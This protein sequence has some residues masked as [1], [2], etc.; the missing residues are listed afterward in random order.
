M[1]RLLALITV[2]ALCACALA[3]PAAAEEEGISDIWSGDWRYVV[4]ED[5]TASITAYRGVPNDIEIPT[6]IDG[7]TVTEVGEK[8]FLTHSITGVKIPDNV[9][10]IGRYGFGMCRQLE[11]I[12]L[13]PHLERIGTAAF[14]DC[15]VLKKVEIPDS[16]S[17]VAGN[18]FAGCVKL[19]EIIVSED[20]PYLEMRDGALFS[21]PDRRLIGVPLAFS[22]SEYAVPEGTEILADQALMFIYY[23]ESI[24][25]PD[26]VKKIG[27]EAI[28]RC[29]NLKS[30]AIPDSVT[31][32]GER[33]F[34]QNSS[35]Q[36]VVLP[37]GLKEIPAQAFY[38]C[39]ALEKINL[40][41]SLEKIGRYAFYNCKLDG[42]EVPEGV[43]VEEGAF[44]KYEGAKP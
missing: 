15:R 43:E 14:M 25:I 32:I 38:D 37:D 22:Q 30:I 29:I 23:A 42:L 3:V 20:H 36:E 28:G 6:E 40:P 18:P 33:A 16:V 21:K 11:E 26:S 7:M 17:Y 13:P 31:E 10:S 35:L 12:T 19:R 34:V 9:I 44:A 39:E 8:A 24:T 1:K 2:I 5:G 4:L 41:A 27:K